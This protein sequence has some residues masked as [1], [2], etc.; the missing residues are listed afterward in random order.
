MAASSSSGEDDLLVGINVTPLVDIVLVLLVIMMV[1]ASYVA[2][3]S[4][5]VELPRAATGETV[6]GPLAITIDEGGRIYVDGAAVDEAGLRAAARGKGDDARA[7]IAADGRARHQAVIHVV[8]VLRQERIT[9]F[10]LDVEQA[11]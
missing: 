3:H 9:K 8:D 10:S 4:I 11:R 6:S 5:P 2:S 7:L 1:T